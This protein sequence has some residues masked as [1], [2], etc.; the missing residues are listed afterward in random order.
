MVQLALYPGAENP[1]M[2]PVSHPKLRNKAEPASGW[3]LIGHAGHITVVWEDRLLCL[4]LF[5]KH[6]G[7]FAALSQ[8]QMFLTFLGT[9]ESL[10]TSA[11]IILCQRSS[12]LTPPSS[13]RYLW[14]RMHVAQLPSCLRDLGDKK[15]GTKKKH[16]NTV[17]TLKTRKQ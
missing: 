17:I 13:V 5:H 12:E 16:Q 8:M 2:V 10:N 9:T 11:S 4:L 15:N 3:A 14:W 6:I 7:H 1:R